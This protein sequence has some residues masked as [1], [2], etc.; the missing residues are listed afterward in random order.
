MLTLTLNLTILNP[1]IC[2]HI[3]DTQKIF[4][5]GIYKMN[6]LREE[7]WLGLRVGQVMVLPVKIR[8]WLI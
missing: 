2:A 4:F 3:V 8:R 6:F 5:F 7:R 1:N